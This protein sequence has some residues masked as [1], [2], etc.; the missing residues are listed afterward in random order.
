MKTKSLL[1][2]KNA[3]DRESD[4]PV[5]REEDFQIPNGE[6]IN[7]W[8]ALTQRNEALERRV[9]NGRKQKTQQQIEEN[10]HP[11]SIIFDGCSLSQGFS[12]NERNIIIETMYEMVRY[13]ILAVTACSLLHSQYDD[14]SNELKQRIEFLHGSV[15]IEELFELHYLM[16]DPDN[17]IVLFDERTLH[18]CSVNVSKRFNYIKNRNNIPMDRSDMNETEYNDHLVRNNMNYDKGCEGGLHVSGEN[19]LQSINVSNLLFE[20]GYTMP[21]RTLRMYQYFSS[22]MYGNALYRSAA[23][24]IFKD[25]IN[26]DQG[27]PFD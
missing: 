19:D 11:L 6:P 1:F 22:R 16:T 18:K 26:N 24:L 10:I 9:L 15:A 27:N 3:K 8:V 12:F 13:S 25:I 14:I 4:V 7:N 23:C 20:S 5:L 2:K 21:E 17:I